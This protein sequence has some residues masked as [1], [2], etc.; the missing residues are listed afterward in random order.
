M[1]RRSHVTAVICAVCFGGGLASSGATAQAAG[2]R[3]VRLSNETT[4]TRFAYPNSRGI[5]YGRPTSASKRLTVLRYLTEDGLPEN[6]LLLSRMTDDKGRV[7][8][9]IRVPERPNGLTGWVL[10]TALG[11]FHKVTTRLVVDRRRLT[12]TLF[13]KGRRIFRA[14][15]G[16]GKPSTPT[17]SGHFWIREHFRVF[18]VPAYGPYAI[19][20]SAHAPTLSEWPNGGVVGI[21]GTD[22]PGLVPGRPS[23]GCMRMRNADITRLYRLLPIGTPLRIL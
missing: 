12:I 17:P 19:G 9:R 22:Q 2:S 11:N 13:R 20:T 21:H 4:L 3:I 14:P 7:W 5:V 23:H 8:V 10:R 16:V 15:L 18:G 1:L 6:Y